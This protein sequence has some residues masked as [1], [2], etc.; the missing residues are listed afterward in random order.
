ML[1]LAALGWPWSGDIW[2][3]WTI[4]PVACGDE[5]FID[6]RTLPET[7]DGDGEASFKYRCPDVYFA[8]M[9]GADAKKRQTPTAPNK[10]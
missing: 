5:L 2:Q 9:A 1:S 7:Y 4:A 8:K 3:Y 6:Y 10:R